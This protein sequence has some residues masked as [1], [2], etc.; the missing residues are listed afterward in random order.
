MHIAQKV[1]VSPTNGFKPV[2][3]VKAASTKQNIS[4]LLSDGELVAGRELDNIGE[5]TKAW[6]LGFSS[7]LDGYAVHSGL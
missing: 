1:T 3:A 4:F 7:F 5:S 6:L 2:P